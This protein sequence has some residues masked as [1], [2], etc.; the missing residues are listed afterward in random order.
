MKSEESYAS[1]I[2]RVKKN[3]ENVKKLCMKTY[4]KILKRVDE[5]RAKK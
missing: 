2:L 5:C 3:L 1:W 4:W